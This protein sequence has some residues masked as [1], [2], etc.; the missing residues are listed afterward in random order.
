[1]LPNM[2]NVNSNSGETM[3]NS[4]DQ[5]PKKSWKLWKAIL[6]GTL[7]TIPG[8]VTWNAG[9]FAEET[10]MGQIIFPLVVLFGGVLVGVLLTRP[11]VSATNVLKGVAVATVARNVPGP[12]GDHLVQQLFKEDESNAGKTPRPGEGQTA[13]EDR[14]RL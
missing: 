7:G 13:P 9:S 6:G 3:E 8:I 5:V 4:G 1:M 10:G 11:D 12:M 2:V 14:N